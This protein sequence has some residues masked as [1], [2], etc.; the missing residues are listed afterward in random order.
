[1][2]VAL[3]PTILHLG[4]SYYTDEIPEIAAAHGVSVHMYA[5]DTQLYLPFSL[6]M[7]ECAQEAVIQIEDCIEDVRQWMTSN[8]LKLND[9][10]TE[11]LIILPSRQVHKCNLTSFTIGGCEINAS[12]S[13]RNLG[14]MFDNRMLMKTQINSIVKN[15]NFQIREIGKIRE[16]LSQEAAT[17]LIHAF[18][19]SRLDYGMLFSPAFLTQ[20]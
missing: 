8:K 15:C 4:F 16:F 20:K 6:T 14:V 9:E 13:V 1:M 5:D 12:S 10:K 2:E 7:P 18:I 3:T 11:L 17:N 19:T